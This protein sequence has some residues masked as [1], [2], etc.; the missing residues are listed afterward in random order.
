MEATSVTV[1]VPVTD[2]RRASTW[3]GRVLDR[4]ADL[5]PVDGIVEFEVAGCW[6]QLYQGAPLA[7]QDFAFRIGVRDVEA[8]RRRL[9]DLG[10]EV[11]A[12]TVI[13][14]VIAFCDFADPDGN[15]L[16][17]YTVLSDGAR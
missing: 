1:G 9:L 8:Q 2:L 13:E 5:E 15:G 6:L 16:S 12:I 4:Q 10:I 11:G 17:L 14:G 7:G 3:Y